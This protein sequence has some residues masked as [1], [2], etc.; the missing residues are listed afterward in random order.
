MGKGVGIEFSTARKQEIIRLRACGTHP[1]RM[2]YARARLC[3]GISGV[4]LWVTVSA[5]G[6]SMASFDWRELLGLYLLGQVP[7]DY[8]GGYWLP[9]RYGRRT[10]GGFWP[11]YV[12]GV[13]VQTLLLVAFGGLIVLLGELGG[14]GA[15]LVG[16]F[17]LMLVMVAGQER[18]ARGLAG[19]LGGDVGYTGGIA[20]LPGREVIVIPVAWGAG[21]QHVVYQR[22]RAAIETGSRTRGVWMAIS[23]NLC[24]FQLASW[25][26]GGG[27]AELGALVQTVLGFALWSFLGLLLLPTVSRCGVFEVDQAAKRLGLEEAAFS[28]SVR[29]LDRRQDDEARR[30]AGVEAIF[31]PLP[32]VESRISGF[33]D[34]RPAFG[35]WNAARYALFL[36][37]PCLG[38]LSR[39]VHCNVGRPELWVFLPME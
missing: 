7:L 13:A 18:L 24:G 23:W 17:S 38:L 5:L 30:S 20:G 33:G 28:E 22:R 19:E 6:L 36:A 3:L 1:S 21:L 29:E 16:Q 35:A 2:T 15:V 37:W 12:R 25:L 32:S 27:V 4:G 34:E 11:S 39:A 10:K 31:H 8:L 14:R 26:P 9:L